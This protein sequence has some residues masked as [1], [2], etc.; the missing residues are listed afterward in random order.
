ML[1][2][3]KRYF[4]ASDLHRATEGQ[5]IEV[6]VIKVEVEDMEEEGTIEATIEELKEYMTATE[7]HLGTEIGVTENKDV[8]GRS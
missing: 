4:Q 6:V 2:V 8:D 3:E 7:R 5:E 1:I